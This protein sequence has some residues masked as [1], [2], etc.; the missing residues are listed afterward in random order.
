MI[1]TNTNIN[2]EITIKNGDTDTVIGFLSS[3]IDAD[4][5]TLNIN[6]NILNKQM[7]IDNEELVKAQYIEFYNYIKQKASEGGINFI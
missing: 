1:K 6:I 4:G 5:Y 7:V 3:S 2:S